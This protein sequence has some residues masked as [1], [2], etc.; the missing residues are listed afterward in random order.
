M[1]SRTQFLACAVIC[2]LAGSAAGQQAERLTLSQAEELALRNHPRLASANLSAD[3]AKAVVTQTRAALYPMLGTS[4][5]SIGADHE[6]TMAAGAVQTSS[7][8]SRV[9]AGVTLSQLITDFGRTG[10]LTESARLRAAAQGE[11]VGNTR[12]QILVAVDTAY[13]QALQAE[14][15]LRSAQAVVESRRLTLR[16][17]RAMAE[18]SLKSTLDVRFA[19]VAVSEAELGLFQAENSV[20]ASRARLASALGFESPR[21][22]SLVDE[23]MPPPLDTSADALVAEAIRQRPDLVVLR[24]NRDAA[25]RLAK[26]ESRLRYPTVSI[27]AVAGGLP[28]GDPRLHGSYSAAGLNVSVPVLNGGLFAARQEEAELRAQATAKDL[29]DLTVRVAE[30]VRVA[31]LEANN[32][33]RRLD[34]TARLLVQA[35][36]ALRLAQARYD[37]GLGSIVELN[38]AQLSQV[39]AQI[40]AASAKYEYL[41]RRAVLNFAIG[42]L[43]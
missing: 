25:Q 32:A 43:R 37:S 21:N 38:Q 14:S 16:Q 10:Q 7:L 36:E 11:N 33:F 1:R 23:P 17:V 30:D 3:A 22:F 41:G 34:V 5:T 4:F 20:Q 28:A 26:A 42:A 39:S 31:W 19:E 6:S 18:G 15:V 24:M 9:A 8:Y 12:A 13:Y 35:N 29:D 2:S 27:V 40:A